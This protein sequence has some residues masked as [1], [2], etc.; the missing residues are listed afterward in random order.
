M[1]PIQCAR[2]YACSMDIYS[3][4]PLCVHTALYEL[5]FVCAHCTVRIILCVL[6]T[7]Y[8]L[9]QI[10]VTYNCMGRKKV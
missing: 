6:T 5:S 1:I 7:L 3:I 4:F 9:S 8:E 2:T 10:T